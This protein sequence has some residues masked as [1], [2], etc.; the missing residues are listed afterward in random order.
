MSD[1]RS[2]SILLSFASLPDPGIDRSKLHHLGD[3]IF[4]TLCA[5]LCGANDLVSVQKF[6]QARLNWLRRFLELPNGIPSHDT[7]GRVIAALDPH[8]FIDCFV[9]WVQSL[10]RS[11]QRMFISIDGKTARA[12]LDRAGSKGPLHVVSAWATQSRL[13]LGQ[14]AVEEKS[15]EITA[16]PALLEMLELSGAVVSIDAMG[17]QKEIVAQVRAQ[18]ADYV[19][20]VKANQEHLEEDI[21]QA[22]DRLDEGE[23]S[24]GRLSVFQTEDKGHGREETRRY[25]A[26]PVP[27]GLRNRGAWQ[28]A[29]SIC[30]VIRLYKDREKECSE[31]RYFL[32]SLPAK[33]AQLAEVIRGHWGI[34]NGLHW[35]LDMYFAEDRNR[36]RKDH[37]AEN[38]ALLR[39]WVISML[40]ND[41]TLTGSIEKKRQQ[42]GWNEVNLE[43]LLGI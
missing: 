39:R 41:T 6:G 40:R 23:R 22:F 30:R 43:K 19:V 24:R 4:I 16:I 14:V 42:A 31:V 1:D 29:R 12:S 13:V 33:A 8:A 34:E 21:R 15:N 36:S 35:V 20:T 38:L 5:V 18:G 25:E 2:P 28:D 9:C 27:R 10:A 11:S 26:L 32:S 7:F 17:C 37:A 3:I